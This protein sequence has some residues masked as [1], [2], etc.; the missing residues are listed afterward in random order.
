MMPSAQG[1]KAASTSTLSSKPHSSITPGC[2]KT[3]RMLV[4]TA[5]IASV[6]RSKIIGIDTTDKP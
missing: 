4:I 1:H 2:E 3:T 5:E 6:S